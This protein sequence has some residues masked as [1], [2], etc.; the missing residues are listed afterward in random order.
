[1]VWLWICSSIVTNL[2]PFKAIGRFIRSC[3][4][5]IK[6]KK[7]IT[8]IFYCILPC[9]KNM[10]Y[11]IWSFSSLSITPLKGEGWLRPFLLGQAEL[12]GLLYP[13]TWLMTGW[14][15]ICQIGP[16]IK[17]DWVGSSPLQD[18]IQILCSQAIIMKI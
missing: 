7:K 11:K 18:N 2:S 13:S 14:A 8:F 10:A 6:K 1:M 9:A 4:A 5:V 17:L 3:A 12:I 15:L 16:S